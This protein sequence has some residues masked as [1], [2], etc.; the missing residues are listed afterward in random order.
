[1]LDDYSF[2]NFISPR[3][4]LIFF[5]EPRLRKELFYLTLRQTC[6]GTNFC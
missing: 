6:Y 2:L 5:C 3:T 1:M 4:V